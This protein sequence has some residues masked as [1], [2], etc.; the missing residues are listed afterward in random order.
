[1]YVCYENDIMM[2]NCFRCRGLGGD[3][4]NFCEWF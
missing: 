1:M 2:S 4:T 3:E